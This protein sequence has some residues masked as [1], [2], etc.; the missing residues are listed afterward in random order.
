MATYCTTS[1]VV[2][3]NPKRSYD[4]TNT[5]PSLTQVTSFIAWRTAEMNVRMS[6]VGISVPVSTSPATDASRYLKM[7]NAWGAA[8]DAEMT[9]YSGGHKNESTHA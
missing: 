5:K 7:I 9:A 3:L 2:T 4:T 8:C 6:A 1:D